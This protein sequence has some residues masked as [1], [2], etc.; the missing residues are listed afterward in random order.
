MRTRT[1]WPS[2]RRKLAPEGICLTCWHRGGPPVPGEPFVWG[3]PS[4]HPGEGPPIYYC[5]KCQGECAR[6]NIEL[7]PAGPAQ[8]S[9]ESLLAHELSKG[10][11]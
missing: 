1:E 6:M 9:P 7:I 2:Y 10:I 5:S 4:T 3:Y 8:R 11:R